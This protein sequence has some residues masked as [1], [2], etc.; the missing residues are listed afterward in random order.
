[1]KLPLRVEMLAGTAAEER[2]MIDE[3]GEPAER[4]LNEVFEVAEVH[5]ELPAA[6]RAV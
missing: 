4:V 6:L 2:P 3:I 1:V 5:G